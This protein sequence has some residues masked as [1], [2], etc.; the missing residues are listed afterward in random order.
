[1]SETPRQTLGFK[2]LVA[3]DELLVAMDIE[4]TLQALGCAV[5]GPVATVA[6]VERL[7]GSA[8]LDGAVLDVNL[9]GEPI[10]RNLPRLLERGL[11]ILLSSGY[12]ESTLFP[13]EFRHLPVLVKPYDASQLAVQIGRLLGSRGPT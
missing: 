3:E 5:I 2:V 13:D 6:E 8:D 7:A 10:F 4:A 11:P 1:M 9:R 12:E